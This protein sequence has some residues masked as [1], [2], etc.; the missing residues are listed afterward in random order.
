MKKP[1]IT[2]ALKAFIANDLLYDPSLDIDDHAELLLDG[3]IDSLGAIRLVGFIEDRWEIEVPPQA[4]TV[5]NFG[6][7]DLIAD[8]V[9]RARESSE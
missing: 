8:Y 3:I 4:M 9:I 5:D 6:S 1:D 7:V 2:T